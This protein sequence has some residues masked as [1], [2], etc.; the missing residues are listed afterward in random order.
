MM[1]NELE[2]EIATLEAETVN[3]VYENIAFLKEQAELKGLTVRQIEAANAAMNTI[4]AEV[5]N[6]LQRVENGLTVINEDVTESI[7]YDEAKTIG[8]EFK[9][10]DY[11]RWIL[12]LRDLYDIIVNGKGKWGIL[13]LTDS[14]PPVVPTFDGK[15]VIMRG[16][17]IG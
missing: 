17:S 16:E 7:Y 8:S 9:L 5:G 2:L 10:K 14:I 15:I 3:K 13:R 4:I 6:V 11:Q 12:C 1:W